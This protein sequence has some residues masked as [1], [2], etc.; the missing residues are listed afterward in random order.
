M[1]QANTLEETFDKMD[2]LILKQKKFLVGIGKSMNN[3]RV[4]EQQQINKD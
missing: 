1:A 2:E 3:E 4:R